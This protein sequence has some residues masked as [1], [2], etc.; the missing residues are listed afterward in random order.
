M[1]ARHA[2]KSAARREPTRPK[3]PTE[4]LRGVTGRDRKMSIGEMVPD[5][6][7]KLVY[8]KAHCE[9]WS[10]ANLRNQGFS[11]LLPRVRARAG[12]APLF[13]R[14]LFVGHE[15]GRDVRPLR[16][17]RGVLYVV[18][19]GDVPVRVPAQVIEEVRARMDAKGVVH[20]DDAPV[21]NALFDRRER[22]RVRALIRLA[23][24]GFR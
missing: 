2:M 1:P 7:W 3:M 18:S 22:E 21:Q 24:A 8:T 16:N 10:E 9:T 4:S 5:P 14:Y 19:L 15:H 6:E 20:L 13:P 11:V 23:Q 12:F 17:T